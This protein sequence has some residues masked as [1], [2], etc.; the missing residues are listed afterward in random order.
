MIL[1]IKDL[2]V[3]YG[4]IKAV[5][6]ISFTVEKGEIVTLIGAN[7]AGKTTTLKTISGL[8]NPLQGSVIFKGGNITNMPPHK[9]VELGVNHVPEGRGIFT[10]LTVQENLTLEIGRA[11]V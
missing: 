8:L 2:E 11:H 1:E 7:G 6:G 10:N 9:I 5:K 3:S 4:S